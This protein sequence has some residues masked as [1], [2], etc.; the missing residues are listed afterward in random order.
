MSSRLLLLLVGLCACSPA[1]AP[2]PPPPPPPAPVAVITSDLDDV[3]AG[4]RLYDAFEYATAADRFRRAHAADPDD[5]G[6][7]RYLLTA[8]LLAGRREVGAE[9]H[10]HELVEGDVVTLAGD[11]LLL[12]VGGGVEELL[13]SRHEVLRRPI[14]DAVERGGCLSVTVCPPARPGE[15]RRAL[16]V[17]FAPT[18]RV[19]D[20][21]GE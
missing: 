8:E 10:P 11:V 21:L 15:R 17:F 18:G 20:A 9:A 3:T 13:V 2:P 7:A 5:C 16:S 6:V 1:P 19:A 14:V 12:W 4:V